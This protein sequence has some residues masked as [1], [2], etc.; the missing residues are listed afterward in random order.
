M[1]CF[2]EEAQQVVGRQTHGGT[3]GHGVEE[4]HVVA[5]FQQVLVQD[6]LHTL[7]LVEEHRERCGTA[8]AYLAGRRRHNC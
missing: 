8:L 1:S 3:V 4:D 7:V 5:S 6:Q 2:P